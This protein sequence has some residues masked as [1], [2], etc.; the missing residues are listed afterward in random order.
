MNYARLNN[1]SITT[2]L[3]LSRNGG[4]R[5]YKDS[6]SDVRIENRTDTQASYWSSTMSYN[7]GYYPTIMRVG[8]VYQGYRLD[9]TYYSTSNSGYN[10]QYTDT[11][12]EL[13]SGTSS[14][15]ANVRCIRK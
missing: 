12:L 15:L 4:Y 5:G 9:G 13:V 3:N 8:S 6:N 2:L 1:T 11:G 14:D 7:G 10:W